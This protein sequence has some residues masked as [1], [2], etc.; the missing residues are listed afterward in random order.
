MRLLVLPVLCSVMLLAVALLTG[1]GGP[2]PEVTPALVAVAQQRWP[3]TSEEMLLRGRQVLTTNCT[4]CHG[5]RQPA[6]H[7][8]KDWDAYVREM[9]PRARLDEAQT[10]DL[11]R[12][13]LAAQEQATH[14]I[15]PVQAAQP[16]AAPA[17]P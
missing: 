11:L 5:V 3:D 16:A 1:C 2:P 12:Y 7:E 14:P 4:R 9:G 17:S 10:K 6:D 15:A 8:P 13:L